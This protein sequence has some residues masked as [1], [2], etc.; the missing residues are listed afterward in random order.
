MKQKRL[1]IDQTSYFHSICLVNRQC[2][3]LAISSRQILC[4]QNANCLILFI[5]ISFRSDALD[6][7]MCSAEFQQ[8]RTGRATVIDDTRYKKINAYKFF[9]S[10][11]NEKYTV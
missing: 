7:E 6:R 8:I 2:L 4:A 9:T 3:I 10:F 11:P 1:N 5:F